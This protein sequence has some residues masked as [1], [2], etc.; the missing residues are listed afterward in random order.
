MNDKEIA[1]HINSQCWVDCT[2]ALVSD[3]CAWSP[4]GSQYFTI[5][6]CP[7]GNMRCHRLVIYTF[8][9]A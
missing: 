1:N 2:I 7:T 6:I 9:P 5:S 3:G 8:S 4:H